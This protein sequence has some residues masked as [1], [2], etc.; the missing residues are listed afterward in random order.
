MTVLFYFIQK[1]PGGPQVILHHAG[2]DATEPFEKFHTLGA[3]KSLPTEKHLGPL[4][5]EDVAI[6]THARESKPKTKDQLRVEE[7]H[8]QK[9]P[10]HRILNLAEMEVGNGP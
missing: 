10:L 3:L 1:H 5:G 7:S 9:P 8:K 2:K 4:T 6:L